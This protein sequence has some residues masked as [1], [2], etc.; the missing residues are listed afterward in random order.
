MKEIKRMNKIIEKVEKSEKERS[1]K[2]PFVYNYKDLPIAIL[3]VIYQYIKWIYDIVI[4]PN[5]IVLVKEF[6]S[7]Y[8]QIPIRILIILYY[9]SCYLLSFLYDKVIYRFYKWISGKG[10]RKRKNKS[11]YNE[12]V[13]SYWDFSEENDNIENLPKLEDFEKCLEKEMDKAMKL[14][15]TERRRKEKEEKKKNK[16]KRD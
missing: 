3:V 8:K 12:K 1:E 16:K 5:N 10:S 6:F 11:K 7:D 9:I 14:N 13:D 4:T 15:R 2:I